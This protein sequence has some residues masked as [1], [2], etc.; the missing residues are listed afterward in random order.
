MP[1]KPEYSQ[2]RILGFDTV[3][4]LVCV[5]FDRAG[6]YRIE[7]KVQDNEGSW[8]SSAVVDVQVDYNQGLGIVLEFEAGENVMNYENWVDM[9]LVLESPSGAVC[10]DDYLN[11]HN[12]CDF[13]RLAR[14][15]SRFGEKKF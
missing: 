1:L 8:S 7:L 15:A 11:S 5:D 14:S 9:D 10:S 4:W 2:A 13:A 12:D 3:S 6:D